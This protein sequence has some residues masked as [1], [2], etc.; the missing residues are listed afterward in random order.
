MYSVIETIIEWYLVT[1]KTKLSLSLL[2]RI[3]QGVTDNAL[4]YYARSLLFSAFAKI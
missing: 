3:P 1:M 2:L 4:N